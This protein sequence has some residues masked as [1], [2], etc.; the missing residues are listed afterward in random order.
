MIEIYVDAIRYGRM[1]IN[2]VPARWRE[3]V[4]K[5]LENNPS[6]DSLEKEDE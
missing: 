4:R 2:Q 1:T 6:N 5:R 3:E